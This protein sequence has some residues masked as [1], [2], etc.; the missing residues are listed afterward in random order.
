MKI[1]LLILNS[2]LHLKIVFLGKIRRPCYCFH[3]LSLPPA[4][5]LVVIHIIS[6]H[7]LMSTF[8]HIWWELFFVIIKHHNYANS[9]PEPWA[10]KDFGSSAEQWE[11]WITANCFWSSM[12]LTEVTGF[13]KCWSQK[14]PCGVF[15]YCC[16]YTFT[17]TTL[18]LISVFWEST[19]LNYGVAVE[20][21]QC[22]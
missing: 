9:A 6:G 5:L 13:V 16:S 11:Q 12:E 20:H 17:V 8:C 14:D 10:V 2:V 4:I 18:Q 15:K 22:T 1:L 3:F 19:Q 21:V 7:M